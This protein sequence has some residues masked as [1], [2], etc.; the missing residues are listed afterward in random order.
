MD[1]RVSNGER[2]IILLTIISWTGLVLK[3]IYISIFISPK[4]RIIVD[5]LFVFTSVQTPFITFK[6]TKRTPIGVLF[7]WQKSGRKI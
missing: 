3:N 6:A 7:C 4:T 1:I 5:L 2:L